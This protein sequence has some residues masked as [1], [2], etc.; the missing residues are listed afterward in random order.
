[1]FKAKITHSH[2]NILLALMLAAI[3]CT[4]LFAVS[5]NFSYHLNFKTEISKEQPQKNHK[6]INCAWCFVSN[7]QNQILLSSA[8]IFVA[9]YF[10]LAFF[11]R[12]FDHIKASYFLSSKASNAPPAIS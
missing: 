11:L 3:V 1:M 5:H 9:S 7:F 6:D 2:K 4:Q 12:K 10:Y 8:F